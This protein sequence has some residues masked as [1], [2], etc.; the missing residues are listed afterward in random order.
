M[1]ETP[2]SGNSFLPLLSLCPEGLVLLPC[3]MQHAPVLLLLLDLL[4]VL[5]MSYLATWTVIMSLTL[6]ISST[7]LPGGMSTNFLIM[8]FPVSTV[9]VGRPSAHRQGSH[10]TP[11]PTLSWQ[12]AGAH[13]LSWA[14]HNISLNFNSSHT[15]RP[16][17][18]PT[19][20]LLP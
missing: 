19:Q 15:T 18:T 9:L 5:V 8:S 7:S 3:C 13:R 20:S 14:S 11:T 2:G 6:M 12:P 1:F 4:W 10:E 16:H 17:P